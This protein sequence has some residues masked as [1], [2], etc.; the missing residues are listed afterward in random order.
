MSRPPSTTDDIF[1]QPPISPLSSGAKTEVTDTDSILVKIFFHSIKT[2]LT[3]FYCSFLKVYQITSLTQIRYHMMIR[4]IIFRQF[5]LFQQELKMRVIM[6][7]TILVL[8][9]W[10]YWILSFKLKR[11]TKLVSLPVT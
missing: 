2:S 1:N 4:F 8:R 5:L 6:T 10:N 7:L 11:W 9:F 3:I